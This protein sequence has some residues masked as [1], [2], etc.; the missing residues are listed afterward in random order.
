MMR[1]D[2]ALDALVGA[3]RRLGALVLR[4]RLRI[5][6]HRTNGFTVRRLGAPHLDLEAALQ[7]ADARFRY[8]TYA[9]DRVGEFVTADRRKQKREPHAASDVGADRVSR[10]EDEAALL[11]LVLPLG[12]TRRFE[13]AVPFDAS[14]F[15]DGDV[16]VVEDASDGRQ[17]IVVPPE[18]TDRR[19]WA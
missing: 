13:Q 10:V 6:E 4:V 14:P 15:D 18:L 17:V 7:L 2:P 3:R 1:P 11:R 9:I 8:E 5:R 12:S 16:H 19:A